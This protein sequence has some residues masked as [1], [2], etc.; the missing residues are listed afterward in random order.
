[1]GQFLRAGAVLLLVMTAARAAQA[2]SP[3]SSPARLNVLLIIADDL[4]PELGCYGVSAINTPNI[5]RL[6]ARGRQFDFAYCQYPV[7]NPSRVSFLTGLRPDQTGVLDNNTAFRAKLPNIITLPQ[8]FR[9]N[10]YF[11]ASLGKVFHHGNTP[12]DAR[13]DMDDPRSYDELKYFSVTRNGITGEGRNMSAGAI[14][15][16]FWLAANGTDEDQP[17]GQI[18]ER[19]VALLGQ[20]KDRPFFIA[21]GFN[22]PHD[23]FVAPKKYFE[24]YPLDSLAFMPIETVNASPLLPNAIAGGWKEEFAKFRDREKREFKR[25]YYAGTS[26][27]DAQIGKVMAA[28]D[29][30]GLAK[31]TIVI[32]LGDHGYHLGE[33]GWWNKN[34]LFEFSCRAPL[35]ILMPDMKRPGRSTR[36]LVEFVDLF[37]TLMD[38]CGLQPPHELAGKTLRPLLEDPQAEWNRPA[39]TQVQRALATG[40][41][42]RTEQWRYIEWSDGGAELYDMH[43]DYGNYYNLA[44]K[45]ES[46]DVIAQLKSLLKP[47]R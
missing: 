24:Q 16:C 47:A 44:A 29:D 26:F 11:T 17:D 43:K 6:S 37:P 9:R 4:R 28:L 31:N 45:P 25:A 39:L 8:Q 46:K 7:C 12:R 15:W 42:V 19:C 32:F 23:P 22:K 36:A 30:L 2:T 14:D 38:Y 40:R 34:T 5:D 13:R 33:R 10:G 20:N 1:M 35:I 3:S 27:V 18:A 21:A 41:S